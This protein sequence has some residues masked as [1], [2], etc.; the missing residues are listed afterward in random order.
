MAQLHILASEKAWAD[1]Q[2]MKSMKDTTP[3]DASA[4][5]YI[6]SRL[7][8]ASARA[9]D[10][11][12]VISDPA[13]NASDRDLLEA[14]FFAFQAIGAE[15]MEKHTWAKG[16]PAFAAA[17]L[18]L[19]IFI[20]KY[21]EKK[22]KEFLTGVVEPS[23]R[24]SAYNLGIGRSV[25]LDVIMRDH[26]PKED[27]TLVDLVNRIYPEA[28]QEQAAVEQATQA[29]KEVE[30]RG[31]KAPVEVADVASALGNVK[32]AEKE[33]ETYLATHQSLSGKDQ[34]AAFDG[35]LSAWQDAQDTTKE[36]ISDLQAEKVAAADPRIQALQ[37]AFTYVSYNLI[38]WRIARDRTMSEGIVENAKGGKLSGLKELVALYD[39]ILRSF[40]QIAQLPGVA[41]DRPFMAEIKAKKGYFQALK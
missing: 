34:A 29:V 35:I 13:A 33:L 41:M 11:R 19:T 8:K 1:A 18:I 22:C 39:A 30:W 26:F 7:H 40:D 20:K 27:T 21:D 36:A 14:A 2:Y 3:L 9:V 28:F 5:K 25:E 10:L 17:R 15:S 24:Y 32:T 4:K 31:R 23:L 12:T 6:K 38:G 16:L 37:I